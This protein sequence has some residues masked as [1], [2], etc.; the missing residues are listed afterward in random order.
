MD[1]YLPTTDKLKHFFLWSIFMS[2]T[3]LLFNI[4]VAYVLNVFTAILWELYQKLIQQGT[5][6]LKEALKDI[7]YG[8][9]L[10]VLLHF[11]T[12]V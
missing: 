6:S 9:C 2:V 5:N 12:T 11:I 1:K 4:H 7:F 8:G 10:P 3:T